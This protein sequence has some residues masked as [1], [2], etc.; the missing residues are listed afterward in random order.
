MSQDR[1]APHDLHYAPPA[2]AWSGPVS[3]A[4]GAMA[5]LWITAGLAIFLLS[6]DKA[7]GARAL[8]L[9]L[10]TCVP[11][12]LVGLILGLAGRARR[13]AWASAGIILNGLVLLAAGTVVVGSYWR[14]FV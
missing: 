9:V 2:P 3:T 8:K 13:G 5:V 11:S 4:V 14:H 6:D 7:E 12:T 1:P 10:L